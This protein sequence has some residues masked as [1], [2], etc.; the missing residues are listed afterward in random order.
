MSDK[1]VQVAPTA[2]FVLAVGAAALTGLLFGFDT[3][4]IAGVTT[5][6]RG[7]FDLSAA[8]L[9]V[10]VSAA[11]WGTLAG[12]LL[13]GRPGDLYGSRNALRVLAILYIASSLGCAAAWDWG[14]FLVFRFIGGLAIGGSSVL[15]P[16][17]LSEISPARRRG[18]LVGLFQLNIVAGILIAYASN[19]AIEALNPVGPDWRWMLGVAAAPALL[20][21]AVLPL[22]PGSPRWLISKGRVDEARASLRSLGATD[23]DS[24]IS[25]LAS[26]VEPDPQ[27][28][29]QGLSWRRHRRPIL[30]VLALAA[31]NQLAGINAVLYYLNDIFA[32]AGF[33]EVSASAQS[34]AIGA[35]NLIFTAMAMAVIDRFGRRTLLLVG[36]VGMGAA[37]LLI[38]AAMAG[39]IP[40][41]LLLWLLM[42]FIAFF[43][44]SQGAVIWVYIGEIF[45]TAV[46]SRGQSLG[47]STHWLLNA[48]IA[49]GFPVLA[50]WSKSAPF[51]LFAAMMALQFVVVLLA[52]PE[53]KGVSLE[54]LERRMLRP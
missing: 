49:F 8:G 1:D 2:G 9:G 44:F 52:F 18:A 53:T 51:L 45:P 5:D 28:G 39:L 4:V 23:P 7:Q 27:R 12:A 50:A 13:A 29:R 33:G 40:A 19:A 14:S 20:L 47:S 43:A 37:L 31:F 16:V 6:L 38:A 42:T 48:L 32:A 54:E 10:T 3:A 24:E 25:A 35:T 11:L 36:S 34:V 15:A 41:H 26:S 21:L 22:V 46:R 30:L 17:Y